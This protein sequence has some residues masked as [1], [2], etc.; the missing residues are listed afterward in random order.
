NLCSFRTV[1]TVFLRPSSRTAPVVREG[2]RFP[3]SSRVL[4]EKSLRRGGHGRC[5]TIWPSFLCKADCHGVATTSWAPGDHRDSGVDGH[6]LRGNGWT[7][8]LPSRGEPHTVEQDEDQFDRLLH[9]QAGGEFALLFRIGD[10]CG[11]RRAGQGVEFG[12]DPRELRYDGGTGVEGRP[13]TCVRK[14][15]G[16]GGKQVEQHGPKPLGEGQLLW[17]DPYVREALGHGVH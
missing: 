11:Q 14:T 1:F 13:H 7:G 17:A 10:S 5:A 16:I 3:C 15:F 8:W 4:D 6:A 12:E 9:E 2:G